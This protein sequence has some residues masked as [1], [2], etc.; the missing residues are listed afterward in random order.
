MTACS[1]RITS[2]FGRFGPGGLP[3]TDGAG[4]CPGSGACARALWIKN[5]PQKEISIDVL[6]AIETKLALNRGS[7]VRAMMHGKL[8]SREMEVA[9]CGGS[10]NPGIL[11]GV[12]LRFYSP[13]R[14]SWLRDYLSS[15]IFSKR[16]SLC[17]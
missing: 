8:L 3:G 13:T 12:K 2:R 7:R 1:V 16:Q 9:D 14:G 6:I 17:Y 11:N 4:G 10:A 5:G 15:A